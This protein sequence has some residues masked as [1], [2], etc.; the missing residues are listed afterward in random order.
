MSV[1]RLGFFCLLGVVAI[2]VGLR[3]SGLRRAFQGCGARRGRSR[4]ARAGEVAPRFRPPDA[5]RLTAHALHP[6]LLPE[7]DPLPIV[8]T[9]VMM[10][11]HRLPMRYLQTEK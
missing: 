8:M 1:R 4:A 3:R 9:L 10:Q 2:A 7:T 5:L 6:P 11:V